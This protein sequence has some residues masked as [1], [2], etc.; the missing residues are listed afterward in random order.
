MRGALLAMMGV[1]VGLVASYAS[2]R[3]L[4]GF[5]WGV[6]TLDLSTFLTVAATLIAVAVIASLVPAIRA[7]RL[8]PLL[9]LRQ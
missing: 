9:A 7:V 1:A 2:V 3:V 5:I 6:S 8:N 4:E